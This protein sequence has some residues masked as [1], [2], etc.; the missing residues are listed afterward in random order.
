MVCVVGIG[1]EMSLAIASIDIFSVALEVDICSM[2]T[3][4]SLQRHP[5]RRN[6]AEGATHGHTIPITTN[7]IRKWFVGVLA[8]C[9]PAR[10][11][12]IS[13]HLQPH[14]VPCYMPHKRNPSIY[15]AIIAQSMCRVSHSVRDFI[16]DGQ[17]PS[18]DA[19]VGAPYPSNRS[20]YTHAHPADMH[21]GRGREAR[22]IHPHTLPAPGEWAENG[23]LTLD[24]A[25]ACKRSIK[26]RQAR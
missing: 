2:T 9:M 5:C 17:Q 21:Y 18:Q 22:P 23:A 25:K 16:G 20:V 11:T 4:I 12:L 13:T 26:T 14:L 24:C 1:I 3:V 7:N 6:R 19:Q 15:T 8:R 10:E